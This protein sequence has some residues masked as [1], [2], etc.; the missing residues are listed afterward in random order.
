MSEKPP[1]PWCCPD[2][3]C[4]P[5]VQIGEPQEEQPGESFLCLGKMG[6]EVTF[7]Y[8]GRS[9][10][11]DLSTCCY[12]PL[13]GILRFQENADDWFLQAFAYQQGLWKLAGEPPDLRPER[14][15]GLRKAVP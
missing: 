2:R 11:N 13:K 15:W 12:T 6:A 4:Q 3:R 1:R 7:V 14:P 9:H 5:L 10:T 8:D